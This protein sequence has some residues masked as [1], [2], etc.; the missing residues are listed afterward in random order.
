MSE[1][2]R[3]DLWPSATYVLTHLDVYNWGPFAGRH[4]AEIDTEGTAIIGQTGSGKTTLVDALMTLIAYQPRYNLASTGGHESDRDLVSYVRGVSGAGRDGD[5]DH[6]ARSGR[7]MSAIAASFSNGSTG[8]TIAGIFTF[9]GSSSAT[10]DLDRVWLVSRQ[11][12]YDLDEWLGVYHAGGKRALKQ[13]CRESADLEMFDSKKAYI[14]QLRRF[15]SVGENAFTL[16]NR[17]AGLKQLN[18][19]DELFR[20]L[21]LDDRSAFERAAEVASEFDDLAAIHQELEIARKQRDS[22]VPIEKG[23]KQRVDLLEQQQVQLALIEMQP[24]CYALRAHQLLVDRAREL[25]GQIELWHQRIERLTT[26]E[27][28]HESLEQDLRDIY[29]RTGGSSLEILEDQIA[30]QHVHRDTVHRHAQDYLRLARAFSLNEALS[31]DAFQ[32]NQNRATQLRQEA[33]EAIAREDRKVYELGAKLSAGEQEL[34][35]LEADFQQVAAR[36]GS[37]ILPEFHK[38]RTALATHLNL[39]ADALPFVAELV[40][41]KPEEATWRGAIERAIGGHRLRILVPSNAMRAALSWVNDRDNRLH[42]RL[43]E[44]TCSARTIAFL[45]DGFTRKL[46]YKDHDYREVV[47]YFLA[48]IDRHCVDSPEKLRRMPHSM[49]SQGLMSGKSGF[50]EKQDKTPLDHGWITGFDNKDSLTALQGQIDLTKGLVTEYGALVEAAKAAVSVTRARL[51]G[52]DRLL[53][54]QFQDI[55]LPEAEAALATSLARK[56]GLIAPNS[57]TA[58]AKQDWEAAKRRL[59]SIKSAK[60]DARVTQGE[61]RNK[62]D[63]ADAERERAYRKI[64]EGLNASQQ[65]LAQ[66]HFDLS[67]IDTIETLDEHAER[68]AEALRTELK[69]LGDALGRIE[70]ELVRNMG[71]AKAADTG[72]LADIG[73][74]LE[75]VP[76][77]RERLKV[78]EDEALP[79]KLNRF[80]S[81]LNQSSDQGVT[82]LLGSIENEVAIIEER[83]EDLN[84]TMR[85]VDFQLGHYLRLDPRRVVH[86]SLKTLQ[87]AQRTLRSAALQD[88]QGESHFRALANVV[89]LLREASDRRTTV[90]ARALLDPRYRL[91]FAVSVIERCT[92]TTVETRSGSQGGSGGEKEIIASYILTASLSYALCPDGASKPLFGTI[93]LD[94]AFSKSSQAVAGRII[95]ALREFGLHPLFVTPNKE[96]RLL[97]SHTRS[98][99]LIHRK[100]QQATMTS[101]SWEELD[102]LAGSRRKSA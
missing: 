3:V 92:G 100:G 18:S 13:M 86:E 89:R 84:N 33:E 91:Q 94:E 58:R 75:D 87:Q 68:T 1:V 39:S 60:E 17:A 98:A 42:V 78:L 51:S 99:I 23:W 65:L 7:T 25:N 83:I 96:M 32:E 29:L 53:S 71:G 52:M 62:R 85:R 27:A 76:H 90:G 48:E 26:E 69:R 12:H 40:E 57:D 10:S 37:N 72:A 46:N 43:L 54:V 61:L 66:V 55:D 6:I 20:E 15:F 47:Q 44:V 70:K 24:V 79:E 74:E 16:L 2:A 14:V 50:F 22:L 64:G 80:S 56:D 19:I 102:V 88:D 82:Q 49:T 34:A 97:R 95:S 8:L 45:P 67:E 77:Y 21:V 9:E 5:T 73:T 93:V 28:Q 38:F 41:V 30:T 36:P 101:L 4:R 11:S 59:T 63:S 81:Y 31:R 35:K